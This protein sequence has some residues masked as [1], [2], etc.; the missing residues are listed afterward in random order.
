M[1][2]A[3]KV[4]PAQ[5]KSP[6]LG[7]CRVHRIGCAVLRRSGPVHLMRDGLRMHELVHCDR[8]IVGGSGPVR[9]GRSSARN[10]RAAAVILV[11]VVA[12]VAV[13]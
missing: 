13:A 9:S 10:S 12:V 4:E 2:V 1:S 6:A 7:R 5:N 8:R 3:P 11:V